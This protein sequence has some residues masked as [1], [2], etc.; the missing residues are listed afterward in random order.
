[1][2][3]DLRRLLNRVSGSG[4]F[5]YVV[6]LPPEPGESLSIELNDPV[7]T[8]RWSELH[9]W[10]TTARLGDLFNFPAPALHHAADRRMLKDQQQDGLVRVVSGRDLRHDGTVAGADDSSRWAEVSQEHQLRAGDVLLRRMFSSQSRAN[11]RVAEVTISDLPLAADS[12]VVT[13][14]AEARL[15]G[16]QR[17]VAVLFLR[18]LLVRRYLSGLSIGDL[19]PSVLSDLRI[20]QP[21]TAL[22]ATLE[23]LEAARVQLENWKIESEALLESVFEDESAVTARRRILVSGRRLRMRVNAAALLDD[24]SHQVRTRYPHPIAYRWSDV[25]VLLS[26]GLHQAAYEAILEAGEVLL[27]YAALVVLSLS[28]DKGLR[29]GTVDGIRRRL[30]RG[31]T[32]GPGFGD[33]ATILQEA[34]ESKVFRRIPDGDPLTDISRAF[35]GP[36]VTSARQRLAQRRND[37]S[38]LR[39][40]DANDLPSAVQEAHADLR[41]LLEHASFLA[42]MPLVHITGLR[43]DA[44]KRVAQVEYEELMGDNALVPSRQRLHASNDLEI[45]SLYLGNEDGRLHLLR[46]YLLRRRCP[47]CRSWET[48]H[49]DNA[50]DASTVAVKSL[51]RGHADV[52]PALRQVLEHVG[53]LE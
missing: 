40:V 9:V 37:K 18:S 29:L 16:P 20:P 19:A 28:S 10:G 24:F 25:Q 43:W 42:D 7:M 14:R 1:M 22:A 33:W 48:F 11:L 36:D 38:H 52:D 27:C 47:I 45:G 39:R 17:L 13:L 23:G 21:D 32:N 2:E 31:G 50:P 46:P 6:P 35:S 34:A 51:E 30:S 5:G 53:L 12:T 3:T 44:L 41:I 4:K 8:A 26:R 15:E 49:V